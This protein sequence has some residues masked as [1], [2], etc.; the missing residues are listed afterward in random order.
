MAT[1][2]VL[3]HR[4]SLD[5]LLASPVIFVKGLSNDTFGM[6]LKLPAAAM[7]ESV[8]KTATKNA[9]AGLAEP[10]KQLF[11]DSVLQQ[12][13]AKVLPAPPGLHNMGNTCYLNSTMQCLMHVP[14]L[15][16]YLLSSAHSEACRLN[17]CVLCRL[18][19]H[20]QRVFPAQGT[21]R[22]QAFTPRMAKPAS[23]K[24]LYMFAVA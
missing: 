15:V 3:A 18:E 21:K 22:G 17:H 23:L 9:G 7:T 13:W 14:S 4:S 20:A 16:Q 5:S 19:D 2:V 6:K 11:D 12:S 10:T 24:R 8:Q 1:D